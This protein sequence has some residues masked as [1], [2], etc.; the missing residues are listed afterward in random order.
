MSSEETARST[1]GPFP[2]NATLRDVFEESR[3]SPLDS[4]PLRL[5]PSAAISGDPNVKICFTEAELAT[6]CPGLLIKPKP[7]PV[8]N[9]C[10]GYETIAPGDG[11]EKDY[12]ENEGG[13]FAPIIPDNKLEKY[14]FG[15]GYGRIDW[16]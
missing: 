5:A 12:G 15:H 8:S 14:Y 16:S 2:M 9:V 13:G 6:K 3:Y 10:N 7:K 4:A 11:Y 1:G